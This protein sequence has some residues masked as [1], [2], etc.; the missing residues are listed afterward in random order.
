MATM[1]P[2]AR[3]QRVREL[4]EQG[5]SFRE[6][7]R[8]LGISHELARRDARDAGLTALTP[9]PGGLGGRGQAFWDH[10]VATFELD[11]H[12]QE[13]LQQ[14]CRLL[15][16]ADALQ[17]EVA[18]HG[19]VLVS[20]RGD[21]R[22]HPAISEERQVSLAIGRLLGQL[23]IPSEDETSTMATPTQARARKAAR[24]RWDAAARAREWR[25]NG[26]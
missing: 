4:R 15:D 21:R 9:A 7:G 10:A 20:A 25:R 16:R 17:A 5:M 13:L 22:P 1:R 23:E 19:V 3:R 11:Q 14:V 18:A 6:I 8:Q 12:E 24:S 2:E 26:A